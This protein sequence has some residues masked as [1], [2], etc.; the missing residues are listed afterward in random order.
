[1]KKIVGI[2]V[3]GPETKVAILEKSGAK[4]SILELF[5]FGG[6]G[7]R[8]FEFKAE[9]NEEGFVVDDSAI[10]LTEDESKLEDKSENPLVG[11]LSRY[12]IKDLVFI[13]SVSE[14][15]VSYHLLSNVEKLNAKNLK[16]LMLE[17][18]LE[19]QKSSASVENINS[20]DF[21]D[22]NILSIY[23]NEYFPV[24]KHLDDIAASFNVKNLKIPYITSADALLADHVLKKYHLEKGKTY[25][26]AYVGVESSRLIF[27]Q[28][29]KIKHMSDYLSVGIQTH[30]F[31]DTII[32]KI[33]LE[34]D[35]AQ[36][37]ELH[38]IFLCGEVIE[39]TIQLTFYGSFPLSDIEILQFNGWDLTRLSEEKRTQIPVYT[40]AILPVL[41]Y[42]KPDTKAL[43][44]IN[45]LP[46]SVRESQRVFKLGTLGYA[47]LALIFLMVV[48][49]TQRFV[50]NNKEI[51]NVQSQ[52]DNKQLVITE[53]AEMVSRVEQLQW[54]IESG[55]QIQQTLDTLV[56]GAEMWTN[57]LKKIQEFHPESKKIW[58]TNIAATDGSVNIQGVG[59]NRHIIPDFSDY[60][61][62]SI[63]KNIISQEIRERGVN[64][65][66]INMNPDKYGY[67]G[68]AP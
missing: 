61:E 27:I 32:S 66:E 52:I 59:I 18:W 15:H 55:L 41:N 39:S 57:I 65:F 2:F 60:L 64:K 25:L 22:G 16:K 47:L 11:S 63:L 12:R 31:H 49:F 44:K 8:D 23:T 58:I 67:R 56:Q 46:E 14:P 21:G 20:V 33:S 42:L 53:N 38:K 34:M 35:M 7:L 36:I 9:T 51:A 43:P 37:A 62:N 50:G 5:S 54:R 17:K 6:A 26:I 24:L 45:L 29:N 10:L 48:F 1:M 30:G 13:P 3:D 40:L 19:S 4:L 28:D 68:L